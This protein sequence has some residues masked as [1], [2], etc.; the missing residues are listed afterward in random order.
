MTTARGLSRVLAATLFPPRCCLCGYA[1]A[2]LDLDLCGFCYVD[3][4]WAQAQGPRVCAFRFEPPVDDLIRD[5][6]YHGALANARVLGVLLAQAVRDA[7]AEL[8]K[9]LIPVPLHPARL[10]ERGFN[11]ALALARYAGRLLEVPSARSVARR[12]RDTPSQT[13]LD[14]RERRGNVSG[15][16]VVSNGRARARLIEAG[17]VAIVDD[18]ITTGSTVEELRRVLMDAGAARVDVW[19]VARAAG[20]STRGPPF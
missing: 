19:S 15:A 11:Q 13:G 2:N 8:P 10:G 20:E 16:F 18:V 1:G 6:K 17:H 3:L 12:I 4:P 9:L 7:R 5:L 14:V